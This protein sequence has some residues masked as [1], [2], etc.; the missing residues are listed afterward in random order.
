MTASSQS[1]VDPLMQKMSLLPSLPMAQDNQPMASEDETEEDGLRMGSLRL[2]QARHRSLALT[3]RIPE[4]L[5]L[6]S[7]TPATTE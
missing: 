7:S 1:T 5:Q 3:G 6:P 2:L 4:S